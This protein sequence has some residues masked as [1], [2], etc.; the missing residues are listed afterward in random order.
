MT[1]RDKG[2]EE[3]G[4]R[5]RQEEAKEMPRFPD[6]MP[7]SLKKTKFWEIWEEDIATPDD[8]ELLLRLMLD[9]PESRF[10][11]FNTKGGS[12][13]ATL[14]EAF[15]MGLVRTAEMQGHWYEHPL[16]PNNF[17][18]ILSPTDWDWQKE[19]LEKGQALLRYEIALTDRERRRREN[20]DT[21]LAI[22][23]ATMPPKPQGWYAQL[24]AHYNRHQAAYYIG[25]AVLAIIGL[26]LSL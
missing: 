11:L 21:A 12:R 5:L 1:R 7:T 20:E 2:L 3:L 10:Y 26:A 4:E 24:G 16:Y 18:Q 22:A 14:N 15:Q 9:N 17:I 23:E 25:G 19:V 6:I 13:P 8:V